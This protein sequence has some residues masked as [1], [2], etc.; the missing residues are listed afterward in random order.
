[1]GRAATLASLSSMNCALCLQLYGAVP[2]SDVDE[3]V[4][5]I[6]SGVI[7]NAIALQ[8]QLPRTHIILLGILPRGNADPDPQRFH[9]SLP[10]M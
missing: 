4:A 1:M 9:F 2:M 7:A 8:E 6:A 3:I 10:S 5:E